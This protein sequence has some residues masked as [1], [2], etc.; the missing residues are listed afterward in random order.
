VTLCI[1]SEMDDVKTCTA[2]GEHFD[3]CE[4]QDDEDSACSGCFPRQA[5]IGHLCESC[6]HRLE[7]AYSRWDEFA[8]AVYG[9]DRMV[10]PQG[11]GGSRPVG[12]VPLPGTYLALDEAFSFLRSGLAH[13]D[14]TEWVSTVTGAADAVRFTRAADAAY[15]AHPIEEKPRKL[16]RVR[17]PRPEC[18]QRTLVRLPPDAVGFPV[19]VACQAC[20]HEIREGERNADGE[21]R[22][23]VIHRAENPVRKVSKRPA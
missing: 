17:C 16:R 12:Y 10:S 9:H 1:T 5:Q 18:G 20:G 4:H 6:W 8:H 7:H 11:G 22:L 2:R 15:R 3:T 23:A 19:V 13:G 14:L 21:E